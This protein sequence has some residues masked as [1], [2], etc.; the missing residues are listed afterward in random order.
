MIY[1]LKRFSSLNS[2][3]LERLYAVVN[4]AIASSGNGMKGVSA[5]PNITPQNLQTAQYNP[6]A[7]TTPTVAKPTTPQPT[8]TPTPGANPATAPKQPNKVGQWFKNAGQKTWNG[9]KTVGKVGLI[10]GAAATGLGIYGL[11]KAINSDD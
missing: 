5:M 7:Q 10:G 1:K 11:S 9:V 8:V 4:P 3:Y 6:T 2:Y